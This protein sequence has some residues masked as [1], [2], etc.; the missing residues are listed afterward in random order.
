MNSFWD[1]FWFIII[2]YVFI[3]YLMMLFNIIGD[4]FRDR[5]LPGI[6][7]GVWMVALIFVPF[8]TAIVYLISRGSGMAQRQYQAVEQQRSKQDEYIRSVAGSGGGGTAADEI[9][10]AKSLLDSGAIDQ[11]EFNALKA[12]ALA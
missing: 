10:R 2:S 11:A 8:V 1:F 7:K 3:A 9:A 6:A 5:E 4:I 12:K